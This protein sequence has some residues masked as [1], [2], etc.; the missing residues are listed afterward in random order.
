[1]YHPAAALYTAELKDVMKKDFRRLSG[2][3][4]QTTLESIG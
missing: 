4:S 3:L 1:M 2:L